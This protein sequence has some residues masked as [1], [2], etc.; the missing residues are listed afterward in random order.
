VPDEKTIWLFREQLT[1][2]GRIKKLFL[3]FDRY[4][5]EQ[6]FHAKVG[7]I[8]DATIIPAPRQRNTRDENKQIKAGE[9][10]KDWEQNPAKLRQKDVDAR[11][12]KK[13]GATFYGSKDHIN[14][15]AEHKRIRK[16]VVTSCNT[17][18]IHCMEALLDEN[19]TGKNVWGDKAYRG[20][21]GAELLAGKFIDKIN[22]RSAPEKWMPDALR[23]ENVRRSKISVRVEHVF[24]F[25]VN[26]MKG[27]MVRCIGMARAESK[28]G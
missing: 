13:R 23:R 17:P 12:T 4:L 3:K 28:I 14:V 16:Y 27:K 5:T 8:V 25:M 10:P 20:K 15:D 6:G 22:F 1:K 21:K 18:D 2:T 7:Q 11:W 26:T 19:N 24:G 9:T